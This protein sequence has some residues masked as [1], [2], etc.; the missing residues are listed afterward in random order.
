MKS[1]FAM[2]AL[3]VVLAA[4]AKAQTLPNP[5][6]PEGYAMMSAILIGYVMHCGTLPPR[7]AAVFDALG[8]NP[9]FDSATGLRAANAVIA[10]IQQQGTVKWCM[11]GQQIVDGLE[12]AN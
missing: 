10:N 1:L 9:L 12:H 3:L 6:S 5:T 4:P 11:F 8:T 2:T 7:S